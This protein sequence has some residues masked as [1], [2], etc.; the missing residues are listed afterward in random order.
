MSLLRNFPGGAWFKYLAPLPGMHDI[1]LKGMTIESVFDTTFT[2]LPFPP[3]HT[4]NTGLPAQALPMGV[5]TPTGK[6]NIFR[7]I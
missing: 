1:E 7:M 2:V 5:G 6:F 3:G 4:P